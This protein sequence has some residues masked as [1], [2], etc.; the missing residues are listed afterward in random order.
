[1]FFIRFFTNRTHYMFVLRLFHLCQVP[2]TY[3]LRLFLHLV[4]PEQQS[5]D[6]QFPNREWCKMSCAHGDDGSDVVD[7]GKQNTR[8]GDGRR[9]VERPTWFSL[10]IGHRKHVDE[11]NDA[12]GGNRLQQPRRTCQ[13][14]K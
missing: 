9:Q 7:V 4:P 10:E 3:I 5:F 6:A 2:T 12:I 8:L 14:S 13:I 11:R 1:M